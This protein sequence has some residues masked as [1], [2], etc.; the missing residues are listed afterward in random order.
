MESGNVAIENLG[1][2]L[3]NGA[4]AGDRYTYNSNLIN[5]AYQNLF[6]READPEGFN[7]WMNALG[8]GNVT[9]SN[10]NDALLAG[11]TSQDTAAYQG[12]H[13]ATGIGSTLG[14]GDFQGGY[15]VAGNSPI[16]PS[17]MRGFNDS[18]VAQIPDPIPTG[19]STPYADAYVRAANRAQEP[20]QINSMFSNYIG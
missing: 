10:L 6:G 9:A 16:A 7:Y 11:A 15:T 1:N 2:A 8:N 19:S 12:S 17:F 3:L 13:S 18:G 4:S 14:G 20:S 5:S